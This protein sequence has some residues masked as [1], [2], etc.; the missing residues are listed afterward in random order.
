MTSEGLREM[1]EGDYAD[2]CA[3]KVLFMSMEGRAEGLACADPGAKTPIGAS[4]NSLYDS[5][6][7]LCAFFKFCPTFYILFMVLY[8]PPYR[9]VDYSS[10]SYVYTVCVCINKETVKE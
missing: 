7:T 5:D 4:G 2:M 1:F 8:K 10:L 9:H 6:T 3:G